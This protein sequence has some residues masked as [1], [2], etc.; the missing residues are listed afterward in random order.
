MILFSYFHIRY[1]HVDSKMDYQLLMS[2]ELHEKE[3]V[4]YLQ[5]QVVFFRSFSHNSEQRKN[6]G[7]VKQ[8]EQP[9]RLHSAS[10]CVLS[11]LVLILH[12]EERTTSLMKLSS[13]VVSW[14]RHLQGRNRLHQCL[15]LRSWEC[16]LVEHCSSSLHRLP[17]IPGAWPHYNFHT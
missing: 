14:S 17:W 9:F 10:T 5:V 2:S 12:T 1:F 15:N 16:F 7:K 4:R 8:A 13:G 11:D 6:D 3:F